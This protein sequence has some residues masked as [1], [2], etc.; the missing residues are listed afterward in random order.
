MQNKGVIKFFAITLAV[1]C[2]FQLSFSFFSS[3]TEKRAKAYATNETAI[4]LAQE[5]ANGNAT[6]EQFYKDSLAKTRE[7]F[8]LDSIQNETVYNLGIRKYTYKEVKE[9]ELNLGL[10]L[11]GGMNVTME[12]DVVDIVRALSGNNPDTTFNKALIMAKQKQKS[13]NA[14]YVT[15]FQESFQELDP[16]ASLASIFNTYELKDRINFNTTNDEVIAVIRT[17]TDG[18]IDHAFNILRTRIDRFGVAQPNIQK[19][20]TAGRILIELPGVTNP[21][22]VRKLLQG[23]AK[24]EFWETYNFQELSQSFEAANAL[25]RDLEKNIDTTA[26][27]TVD[28]NA[29]VAV[30][31]KEAVEETAATDSIVA[32]DTASTDL[33]KI[34]DTMATEE[35]AQQSFEEY[36]K[37]NPLFARLTP[38]IYQNE[39]GQYVA[40]ET[41]MVG[42][43]LIRDTAKVGVM[44]RQV[45]H[46][47][48][49]NLKLLWT[50][51]PEKA[52]PD[53]LHLVAIKATTR[54]GKPRLGGEAIS[55]ARQDM[56]AMNG[57]VE[58]S[59][60]MN[61]EGARVW[62]QMTGENIG[63]QIAIV[64]DGFVYSYPN[65]NQEISG[66][67]SSIS[68]GNMTIEE[69][70]DLANILK[71]G[72]M[73]AP[74]RIVQEE[75]V[76]PSLGEDAINSGMMSIVLAFIMV[77]VYMFLYYNRAGLVADVALV[78][79]LFFL[80]GVLASF[81]A[82]LT[83]P[84]IAGIVLTMGM[85]V[86]ANVIIYE[87][88]K[89]E[90]KAGKALR[91]SVHDGY[92][93]AYS[94][95]I[96]GNV[97]TL[98]TAI[99]LFVF[100]SG[101]IQGFATTLIIGV[102]ASLFTAI[103]I[104]RLMFEARLDKNKNISFDN[105]I[106]RTWFTKIH[107]NFMAGRKVYY[108]IMIAVCVI[109]IASLATLGLNY[110]I[111]F[112]GGRSYVVRFDQP[113][114][115]EQV[116]G[117][118]GTAFD[119]TPEVKTFGPS[120]QVKITTDYKIEEESKEIDAEI[121]GKLFEALK[122][123]YVDQNIDQTDFSTSDSDT[124]KHIGVLS[125]QKVGPTIAYDIKR[126]AVFAIA[127][128]LLII[129]AYIAVRFNKWQFGLGAVTGL[130][131]NSLLILGTYSLFY[132]IMPFSLEIDQTFIAAILTI[133]GYA[134][135][136]T[137][138]I[139]DRIREFIGLYPKRDI[140]TNVNQALNSTLSRTINTSGTT[141][142]VLLMIFFFGGE[143]IRGFAFALILGIVVGTL[144]SL[145]V[146]S[147]IA[148]DLILRSEKRKAAKAAL[149][150]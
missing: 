35:Q 106:T 49:R 12:V 103:F 69:A 136:D 135:N 18:A 150:K 80:F 8:Y 71:S 26:I 123:F 28:T 141:L 6:L 76:G 19:L 86:D 7:Q 48:P 24:L 147:P 42:S 10:D 51:K 114:S 100:G 75:I 31:D 94:A 110:G 40:A 113:I 13:S 37:E 66:G 20:Q 134:V 21:E 29:V 81:G 142:V 15:L 52:Q 83:L 72:K 146:A 132:R 1:V 137:V 93:N 61:P 112:K 88:I 4:S 16:N 99:V 27:E 60:S 78:V 25:L 44:L 2:L 41:A 119:K 122:P 121:E 145:M 96:D 22:R 38:P 32:E 73:P 107:F 124:E 11:K 9:R 148:H 89:E 118:L 62:K 43:C 92:K 45:A 30:E 127:F 111:D 74:A 36:A 149:K 143:V 140:T 50:V 5:L 39:S 63:K 109:S 98:L 68:G 117:A 70:Q 131:F 116:R 58:V 128:A 101:P 67:R 64:L 91:L 90:L 108:G 130:A 14:D 53:V 46:L 57:G 84:G 23:S 79:N 144:C 87:R 138:V 105:S 115:V 139:F 34:V 77:L 125:S 3:R 54:D 55:D 126:N 133:I 129:F 95:I 102:L 17:E 82:V 33:E 97:T 56:N 65:V 47:F 120:S 59:M 85:A 104:T